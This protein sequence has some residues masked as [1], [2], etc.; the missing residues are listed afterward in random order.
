MKPE[1]VGSGNRTSAA[2][3]TPV[4][5]MIENARASEHEKN[6]ASMW[7]DTS[8]EGVEVWKVKNLRA[9]N[10]RSRSQE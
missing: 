4:V 3:R 2:F 6:A 1:K 7:L 8:D 9:C 5:D 10:A